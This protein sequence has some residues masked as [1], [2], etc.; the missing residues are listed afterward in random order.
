MKQLNKHHFAKHQICVTLREKKGFVSLLGQKSKIGFVQ[1]LE[2][3][4]DSYDIEKKN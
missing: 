1:R 2:G 3:K 4:L